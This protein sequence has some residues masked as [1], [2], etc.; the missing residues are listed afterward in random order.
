MDPPGG[1]MHGVRTGAIGGVAVVKV[2]N[3][4]RQNR[5]NIIAPGG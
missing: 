1:G 2:E 5:R 4:G 3:E